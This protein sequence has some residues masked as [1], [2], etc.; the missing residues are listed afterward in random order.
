MKLARQLARVKVLTHYS[1]GDIHC[2]CCGERHLEFLALDHINGGGMKHKREI[3][4]SL[5]YW[6]WFEK[7]G[8]PDGFRV[9]CHNCN[10][11]KGAYGYC[12]HDK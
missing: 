1:N 3:R 2:V 7:E 12:P 11:S 8:W 9:L 6:R 10:M 5:L 4:G